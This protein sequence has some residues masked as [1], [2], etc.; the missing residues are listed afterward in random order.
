MA[1]SQR[2]WYLVIPILAT[3]YVAP[4]IGHRLANTLRLEIY[5]REPIVFYDVD[6]SIQMALYKAHT[7]IVAFE[8]ECLGTAFILTRWC[9]Y[10]SAHE[11]A[12]IN[13]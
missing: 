6:D 10:E 12:R 4:Y 7:P 1:S 11:E 5:D 9:E 2:N 8:R 13:P 3:L